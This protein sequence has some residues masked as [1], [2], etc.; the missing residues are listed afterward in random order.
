MS[1]IETGADGT[2]RLCQ[3]YSV[4]E[5]PQLT[6]AIIVGDVESGTVSSTTAGD[7]KTLYTGSIAKDNPGFVTGGEVAAAL[8]SKPDGDDVT[9][10]M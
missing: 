4:R 2:V 10:M 3:E 8:A 1:K 7:I 5:N 9:A 6:D